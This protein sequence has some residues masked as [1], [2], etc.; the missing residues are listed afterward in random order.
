MEPGDTPASP[1]PSNPAWD[2]IIGSVVNS[3]PPASH[4]FTVRGRHTGYLIDGDS[5]TVK[6][7]LTLSMFSPALLPSLATG[8]IYTYGSFYSRTYYGERTDAVI[9]FR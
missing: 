2:S 8:R 4:W 5:G 9:G 6:G 3:E 1:A 7:T